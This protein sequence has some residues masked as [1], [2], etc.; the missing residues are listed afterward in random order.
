VT[1][2]KKRVRAQTYNIY[3]ELNPADGKHARDMAARYGMTI[4]AY[5]TALVGG[6]TPAPMPAAFAQ[7]GNCVSVPHG[8]DMFFLDR[9]ERSRKGPKGYGS[10]HPS[11]P[12]ASSSSFRSVADPSSAIPRDRTV[13]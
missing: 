11:W 6:E 9:I 5:F 3:L 10:A 7:L 4:T 1:T 8:P 13:S 12:W 2:T